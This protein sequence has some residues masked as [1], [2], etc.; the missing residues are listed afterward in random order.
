MPGLW[1]TIYFLKHI[2]AHGIVEDWN[3]LF[4]QLATY[5]LH[6]HSVT[7]F[8][9][10]FIFLPS[11]IGFISFGFLV[12]FQLLSVLPLFFHRWLIP[13]GSGVL[14]FH[15]L[16]Y[17]LMDVDFKEMLLIATF[18]VFY[19]WFCSREKESNLVSANSA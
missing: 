10:D 14:I 4:H 5:F 18:V 11:W 8:G 16:V 2:G 12:G 3:P 15:S 17:V 6:S 13:W 7:K 19:N 9:I 1:K